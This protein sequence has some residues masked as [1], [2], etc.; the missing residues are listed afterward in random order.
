[1]PSESPIPDISNTRSIRVD[2]NAQL[3]PPD[4]SL[5]STSELR[6]TPTSRQKQNDS[7]SYLS[8][9][10]SSFF[11]TS[12][13]SNAQVTDTLRVQHQRE[14]QELSELND[15][16]RGYLDRV[17]VLENK[18]AKIAKQLD[19][20]TKSWGQQSQQILQ[21]DGPLLD[22]LRDDVNVNMLGEADWQTRLRRS[23][24]TIDNYRQLINHETQWNDKQEAKRVSLKIEY[25]N[26]CIE[27]ANL[28]KSYKQVEEQL[29]NLLKQREDLLQDIEKLNEQS[30]KTTMDRIKLDL[31]VQTLREE[32]PFLSDIHAHLISEF[33]QL[34]P[35]NGM[36]TQQFYR[37]ELEK[38]IYDIRRDFEALHGAQRKEMEEYY[39][40][41]IEEMQNDYKKLV[42]SQQHKD[43][44]SKTTEH[45]KSTK[46]DIS[47]A[48]KIL[49]N[50]K[51]KYKDL[52]DEYTKL[53]EE[54]NYA[55]EK[56][57]DSN[58]IINKELQLSQ[59][60]IQQ[61]TLEIDTILRSN[62]TLQS[63]INVYRRLLDS[64][65]NRLQQQP[66]EPPTPEPSP[67]FGSELGK[68]FNRKIK[69]G[70]IAIKDCAPD[71][72]FIVLEN[73]SSEKDVDVSNWT[74]RRRVDGGID[75]QYVIPYGVIIKHGKELKIYAKNAQGYNHPPYEI[76]NDKLDSWGMGSDIET[77]LYNEQSE[78]RA[79]HTQKIVFGSDTS[80]D[81][82]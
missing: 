45:I 73:G 66:V 36:D 42:P 19:G 4:D 29:K 47:D 51:E 15:R 44:L 49:T 9:P 70:P 81:L 13:S 11:N 63:E 6:K 38:A 64:E 1:M 74:I 31:Q 16:F 67:A 56:R 27:L 55:R 40:V 22:R 3:V 62:I 26:S 23:H 32:I 76:V 12:T 28:Q 82:S 75:M 59:D 25:D 68:V 79:S 57:L 61:L 24:Y 35:S 14:K 77:K 46:L 8:S 39:N 2:T 18:N 7:V 10:Q 65:T 80:R 69:K 48:L 21:T 17:K 33:D 53:E 52:Q 78:E 5:W 34:K 30:Y 72:K 58:S 43:D 37:Q 71:G 20:V 60:K 50:E 54:L 41:K